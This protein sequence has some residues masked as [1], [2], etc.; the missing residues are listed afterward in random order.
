M[1][2]VVRKIQRKIG[3]RRGG[4]GTQTST[5][6]PQYNL[7]ESPCIHACP[8]GE[9]IRAYLVQIAQTEK[10]DWS[11]DDAFK[12]AWYT[13]TDKNPFPAVMGR[14]CP[15]PCESECN[16]KDKDA[17]VG[18]NNM[19]R[20]IG[21]YGIKNKLKLKKVDGEG[22]SE[23]VAVV[24]AGPS[25]LSCAYQLARRGYSVTVFEM[26][27]KG[28]GMLRFGIPVYRLPDDVLDAEI[29]RIAEMGV[30]IKYNTKIGRDI[31]FADLKKDYKAI[32]LSIGAHTGWDMN[33]PG[34]D[35][36][37]VLT[38]ADYLHKIN[39]GEK[40]EIGNKVVV[41]GGG[42]TAIDAAMTSLRLG[43]D[44]TLLYRRTRNEMPAIDHDIT[45]AEE[46]GI[47]FEFLSAPVEVIKNG[48][49]K[50]TALKCLKMELGEPDDSGRRRPVP[51]EGSE[52]TVDATAIISAIGQAP[53]W[54]GLDSFKNEKGW[55]TADDHG[56][57]ETAGVFAGGDVTVGLGIAT[58]AIGLG[59]KTAEAIHHFLRDEEVPEPETLPVVHSDAMNLG[60]YVSLERQNEKYLPADDRKT[61]F[62]E[63]R[64]AL[65]EEQAIEEA[66]R[67][68][69]CGR[70]FDC[71][72]CFT[73]CS[74]SAVKKLD[75]NENPFGQHYKF[76]LDTCQGCK[77]CAEECPCGYIDMV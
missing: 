63:L 34:E 62:N 18:I 44:V 3:L 65:T 70:C 42:D 6:R 43:A 48:D 24:G 16:R 75:K 23:K 74:D 54:E 64:F 51:I 27:D 19:E 35:A 4:R 55:I 53:D 57:T 28:G 26:F 25:G 59:R 15:H 72:N 32:Y 77:K 9:D 7:K 52:Y 31:T 14:V 17:A 46:E 22:G 30:E 58:Q 69:S 66:K 56:I 39:A 41:I 13:I 36:G 61:N 47:N 38:G 45:L 49:G 21:D 68:M 76:V 1:A 50:A 60:H 11:Y 2:I 29:Q 10:Y 67:C 8:S 5:Q 71:D 12:E 73:F 37:N 33:I 40:V 20:F